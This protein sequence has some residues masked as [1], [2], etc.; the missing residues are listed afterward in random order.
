[1]RKL[2]WL[3]GTAAAA[4][5]CGFASPALAAG[6]ALNC[7]GTLTGSLSSGVVV[8][9]NGSCV[10]NN[11]TVPSDVNVGGN[12]YFEADNTK[13][14]GNVLG[15]SAETVFIHDGSRVGGKVETLGGAQLFVYNSTVNND[16]R[17]KNLTNKVEIC[18]STVS[19]GG[20]DVEGLHTGGPGDEILI[21]DP[22]T[23]GCPGNTVSGGINV[24]SNF[25][26]VY[27]AIRGNPLNSGNPLSLGNLSVTDNTGTSDKFVQNNIGSQTL[28]LTCSNNASP[29][30]GGPSG[31]FGSIL[32]QCF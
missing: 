17:A 23:V 26:D 3:V 19:S 9:S 1:M 12:G 15:D 28:T 18:G 21:G 32:G 16:I 2:S 27:F 5:L 22:L 10:L 30:V 4:L 8:P 14:L 20:I 24:G 6:G 25:T 7:N 13:M 29:F 11:A 31:T